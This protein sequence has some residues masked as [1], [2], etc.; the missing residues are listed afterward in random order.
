V[1]GRRIYSRY[2]RT[3]P[4]AGQMRISRDVSVQVDGSSSE[5]A[6]LSDVPGV[7][8]EELTLAL[9]SSA[10]NMDLRVKVVDSRP[11]IIEGVLRHRVRLQLLAAETAGD[12]RSAQ[13]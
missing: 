6:V 13:Q 10:G 9:V 3:T 5:I 11:Q 7:V 4:W 2:E 8:D 1:S 12:D